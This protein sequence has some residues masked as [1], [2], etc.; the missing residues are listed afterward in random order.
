MLPFGLR[1][2]PKI[3]NAVADALEWCN[4][5]Q[6][7]QHIFHYLDNIIVIG[8]PP[9]PCVLKHWS[10]STNYASPWSFYCGSQIRRT[11][12][13][14]DLPG[15]EVDTMAGELR[16]PQDKLTH[17]QSL[18][19]KWKDRKVC[20]PRDLESLVGTLNHACRVVRAGRSFLQRMLDL[21]H[22]SP[23]HPSHS[24]SIR[25]NREFRSDLQWWR[26]FVSG[27]NGVSF[28]SPPPQLL[29]LQMASDASGSWGCGALP[30]NK[31]FQLQWDRCS[32]HL[33]VMVNELLP[34]VLACTVWG[35]R[36]AH[37]QVICVYD[38]QAVVACL[39]SR[40]CR[41]PHIMKMLHML[42]FV[43]AHLAFSLAPS[44]IDTK[45]SHLANDLSCDLLSS[46]LSKV[47]RADRQATQLPTL[48]VD[49]LLDASLDWA[50]PRL[51]HQFNII[52]GMGSHR[53]PG[54]HTTQR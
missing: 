14:P 19:T 3:F 2:A 45:A 5:H 4:R 17:L 30:K 12:H 25:L 10:P 42:A 24:H 46:F 20:S 7:V 26:A 38:N 47:P 37:H 6:G 33:P 1:S 35:P 44:Y 21:L 40:T 31:W 28:L 43:E 34:I 16:L 13:M 9:L 8:A 48:L 15:I 39:H 22:D 23:R 41:V 36:W 53:P 29:W 54:A 50:S 27:W 18:L 11:H 32:A 51:H 49:L 52:L